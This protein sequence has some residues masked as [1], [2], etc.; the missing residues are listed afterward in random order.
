MSAHDEG[1]EGSSSMSCPSS[2]DPH[3]YV[4]SK[5]ICS[6]MENSTELLSATMQRNVLVMVNTIREGFAARPSI[7]GSCDILSKK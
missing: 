3:I 5:A 2:V 7:E 4:L 1:T 6:S